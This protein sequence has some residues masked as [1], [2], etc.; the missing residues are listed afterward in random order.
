M[1]EQLVK[2]AEKAEVDAQQTLFDNQ[3]FIIG[4]QLLVRWITALGNEVV[5][6][7]KCN[8]ILLAQK[9]VP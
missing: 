9:D 8:V 6:Q 7:E 4:H 2:E 5:Q 3:P 1:A